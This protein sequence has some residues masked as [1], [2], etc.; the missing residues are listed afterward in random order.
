MKKLA[1]E[2]PFT[3]HLEVEFRHLDPM[4]HVN[5]AVFF[6]YMESARVRYFTKFFE[7][8]TSPLDM[9]LILAEASCTY[10]SPAYFGEEL[11]VGVAITEFG[12]R[13]F[14]M[15]YRIDG[16]ED[17]LIA[18]G[19]TVIVMYDYSVGRSVPVPEEFKQAVH[20]FQK[21]WRLLSE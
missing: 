14:R 10:K 17:R 8:G 12:N 16:D 9:P 13:S 5:N 6:T 20:A 2:Y 15:A 7:L 3:Y 21:D 18:R 1:R 4:G 11:T 19:T